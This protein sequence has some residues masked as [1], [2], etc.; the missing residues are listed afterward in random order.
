MMDISEHFYDDTLRLFFAAARHV[1]APGGELCIHT[2]N[3]GYYL[4]RLKSRNIILKQFPSHIAVR[5]TRPMKP[6]CS[7]QDSG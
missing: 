1:L 2:P 3:V 5:G 4:E 6:L 7:P